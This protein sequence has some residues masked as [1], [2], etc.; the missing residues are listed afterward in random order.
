MNDQFWMKEAYNLALLA[1]KQGEVPIGA[2]LIDDNDQIIGRGW[3]QVLHKHDPSAHAEVL[4]LR[5]AGLHL[6]NYRLENTTLY[7]TLEPCCMCA[8]ALVQARIKR[9][10]FATRD[11]KSGAAGSTFNIV[12]DP[13]LNHHIQIDEGFL[14]QECATLLTEFFV[15]RR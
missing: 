6:Q 15:K 1:Q 7:V 3:N 4:A 2:I 12:Q 5:E 14:Q 11:F 10:V 8:G 13:S 9:L